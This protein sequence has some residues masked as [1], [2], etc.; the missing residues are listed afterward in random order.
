MILYRGEL[1]KAETVDADGETIAPYG[2]AILPVTVQRVSEAGI[3]SGRLATVGALIDTGASNT[4]VHPD[5]LKE[6]GLVPSDRREFGQGGLP[7]EQE[8][9][10]VPLYRARILI[11]DTGVGWDPYVVVRQW[12]LRVA[13]RRQ[14]YQ[15]LIGADILLTCR[16]TYHGP[17]EGW[18]TLELPD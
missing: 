9:K 7:E 2:F 4:A 6:L 15:V 1:T 8:A 5:L 13:V 11:G 17:G 10:Y 14:S 3:V 18:F 16:F 12:D